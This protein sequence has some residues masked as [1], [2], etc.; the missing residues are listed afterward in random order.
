MP[1]IGWSSWAYCYHSVHGVSYGLAQSDHIKQYFIYESWILWN[2]K[3]NELGSNI[4]FKN[5][6]SIW[7]YYIVCTNKTRLQHLS[8]EDNKVESNLT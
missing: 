6:I 1:N 2:K 8:L 3:V 5:V 7:S 4:P